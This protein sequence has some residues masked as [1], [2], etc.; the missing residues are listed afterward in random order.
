ML[1]RL[2]IQYQIIERVCQRGSFTST[3]DVGGGKY[4]DDY[5]YDDDDDD[6]VAV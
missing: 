3:L 5:H 4:D 2:D 1:G 6:E